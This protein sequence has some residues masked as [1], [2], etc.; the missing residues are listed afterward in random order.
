MYT[1]HVFLLAE[2]KTTTKKLHS[3]SGFSLSPSIEGLFIEQ[4]ISSVPLAISHRN[5]SIDLMTLHPEIIDP[6]R[7]PK[8]TV[9]IQCL[10]RRQR[11]LRQVV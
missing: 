11:R 1:T 2:V 6:S 4:V 7:Q 5:L 9:V 8:A 10:H 3:D